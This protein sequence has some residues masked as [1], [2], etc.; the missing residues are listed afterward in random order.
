MRHEK[1]LSTLYVRLC[2]H[3]KMQCLPSYYLE[4]KKSQM[5]TIASLPR[6]IVEWLKCKELHDPIISKIKCKELQDSIVP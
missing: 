6:D 3:E 4:P 2:L 1:K 5:H